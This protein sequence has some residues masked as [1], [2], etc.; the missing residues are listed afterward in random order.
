MT[1]V[2]VTQTINGVSKSFEILNKCKYCNRKIDFNKEFTIVDR[3][4][5]HDGCEALAF[6]REEKEDG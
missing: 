5:Y 2:V 4:G 1:K 3:D 6:P